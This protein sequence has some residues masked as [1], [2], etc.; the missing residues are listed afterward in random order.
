[1]STA[2]R[3][4]ADFDDLARRL[5]ADA[6]RH[7]P[8]QTLARL[9]T[10][11]GGVSPAGRTAATARAR[12]AGWGFAVAGAALFAVAVALR[13]GPATTDVGPRPLAVGQGA[14]QAAEDRYGSVLAALE[15]DPDFYLWLANTSV[16]PLAME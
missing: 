6:L 7:I 13:L 14:G 12:T 10:A 2:P 3:A 5:H 11:S 8:W 1:M 16:Q 15:E 4:D 9:R